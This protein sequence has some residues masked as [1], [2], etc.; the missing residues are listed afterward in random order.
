[1]LIELL[2]LSVLLKQESTIYKIRKIINKS[3]SLFCRTSLGSIYPSLQKLN[4]NNYV[5]VKNSMS[6]G[7]Q[8]S[9]LYSIT[10][11]GKKHFETLMLEELPQNPPAALQLVDIKTILLPILKEQERKE[12]IDILKNYY[13]N[14]LLEID[15]FKDE[16]E[17]SISDNS[18]KINNDYLR[19]CSEQV[20]EKISWL[21]FQ[22]LV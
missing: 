14:R 9:S 15:L 20:K 11:K 10:P 17:A 1:M 12:V 7:G 6:S 5:K 22:K 2:I 4:K 13:R 8:K 21:E 3:F 18:S 16:Q 19:L